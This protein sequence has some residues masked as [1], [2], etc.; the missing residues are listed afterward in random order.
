[1]DRDANV[2]AQGTSSSRSVLTGKLATIS[3]AV[4]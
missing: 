3:V 1:M 4:S 2:C